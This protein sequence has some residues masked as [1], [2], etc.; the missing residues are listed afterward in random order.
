M[1]APLDLRWLASQADSDGVISPLALATFMDC[2]PTPTEARRLL[3]SRAPTPTGSPV[4]DNLLAGLAETISDE[5]QLPAPG[6]CERVPP[7]ADPLPVE[8]T[9]RMQ[10]KAQEDALPRFLVR[11]ITMPRTSL[12][13]NRPAADAR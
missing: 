7:L 12:F 5:S 9:P 11:G 10:Q 8:G 2:L 4:A 6:W 13:R 3:L 1:K